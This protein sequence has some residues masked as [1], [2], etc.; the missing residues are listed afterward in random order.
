M[1][2]LDREKIDYKSYTYEASEALSGEEVAEYLKIDPRQ[3]FKTLV[4]VGK[5]GKYYVFLVAVS[6]ELDLKK[7]S[8]SVNEK[9]IQM[10]KSKDLLSLTGYIH[11][12]CSPIGMKKNFHTTIDISAEDQDRII[13]NGG[14]I[15]Y[16]VEISL[17]DLRKIIDFQLAEL[18]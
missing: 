9:S 12:G 17:E 18:V 6:E 11:G 7:A 14:K 8:S 5:S 10:I 16:Q 15:G 13:F 2:I 4:T 1:R 3:I